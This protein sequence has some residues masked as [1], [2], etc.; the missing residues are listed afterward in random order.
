MK[1]KITILINRDS[2]T[3][4]LVDDKSGVGFVEITLTAEQL[5]SAL[6]RM[7]MT[8]C[9]FITRGLDVIGKQHENKT[10]EFKIPDTIN[11]NRYRNKSAEKQ[12]SDYADTLLS[13][14]WKAD[15]YFRSQNSF[16]KK[17]GEN[18]A[19]CTIRRYV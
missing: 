14:G 5:S 11:S 18:W 2:T 6:S 4:E 3:I 17:D 15:V 9:E 19:R 10:F 13:D 7:S 12:L 8:D 16:F 1:G